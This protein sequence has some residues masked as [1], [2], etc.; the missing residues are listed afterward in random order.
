MLADANMLPFKNEAFDTVFCIDYIH[1]MKNVKELARVLSRDGLLI[2]STYCN[3]FNSES[4]LKWLQGLFSLKLENSFVA[5]TEME[6][7]A[8]AVFRKAYK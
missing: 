2:V 5:K 1:L 8:V 7:D 3:R 6:W 4:R